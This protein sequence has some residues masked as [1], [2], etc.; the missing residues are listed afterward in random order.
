MITNKKI[1]IHYWKNENSIDTTSKGITVYSS[2]GF[3]YL[4]NFK[5]FINKKLFKSYRCKTNYSIGYCIAGDNTIPHVFI[6]YSAFKKGDLIIVE[7]KKERF[8]VTLNNNMKE[9]NKLKISKDKG[10]W[11]IFFENDASITQIE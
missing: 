11:S 7:T 9:Y 1:K 6:P 3:D 4:T 2:T 5:I 10:V 8:K